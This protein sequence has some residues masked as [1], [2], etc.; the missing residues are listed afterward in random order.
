MGQAIEITDANF[1]EVVLGSDKLVLVDFWIGWSEPCRVLGLIVEE[2]AEEYEGKA[3]I[4][5]LNVGN[6]PV[7]TAKY[8]I[9]N[10]PTVLIFKDGAIVERKVGVSPK[11][12]YERLLNENF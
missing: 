6:N 10:M 12:V 7:T 1:E 2:L 11:T 4:G 8:E 3:A 5:K 9:R